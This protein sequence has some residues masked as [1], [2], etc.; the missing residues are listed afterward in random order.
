MDEKRFIELNNL[1]KSLKQSDADI[2]AKFDGEEISDEDYFFY[3]IQN[4][5]ISNTLNI[6]VN[7]LTGNIESV[8]VDNSCRI[9]L[10]VLTIFAMDDNGDISKTQK[11]IY[12]YIYSY[13]DLANF[14]LITTK[15]QFQEERFKSIKAVR[16]KCANYIKKHFGCEYED[17]VKPENGVDDPCFYLKKNLTDKIVFSKLI[18]KY[19][20]KDTRIGRL[21]EFFSIMAHPRYEM[22]PEVEKSAMQVHQSFVDDV[23]KLVTEFLTSKNLLPE[24]K[25]VNDFNAD[26]FYNPILANNVHN[27][28]E[29]ELAFNLTIDRICNRG[30]ECDWFN[31]FFLEK[32]KYLVLDMLTSFSLGYLEHVVTTF[33]PFIELFGVFH[34]VKSHDPT[35][36]EYLKRCYWITSRIQFNEHF[37]AYNIYASNKDYMEELQSLY[38]NYYSARYK[39]QT[40][41]KFYDKCLHNSLYF[42]DNSKKSFNK[43]V[44]ET[45]QDIA[46]DELQCKEF[47][48]LYKISKDM[49][50]ASG[51]SFNATPDLIAVTSHRAILTTLYVICHFLQTEINALKEQGADVDLS[52]VIETLKVHMQ[53]HA[54]AIGYFYQN[55][56]SEVG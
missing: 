6:L 25:D 53:F 30:G 7:Y 54:D 34:S 13:V 35:E 20:A 38:D 23:L 50:H 33:K 24:P 36:I 10:E 15:E 2:L 55:H 32:S 21:Y 42:L 31:L 41:K 11:R 46:T 52:A 49:A 44:R 5:I 47:I 14:K 48:I 45:F 43:F 18:D 37:K 51:Y 19:F 1:Y 29:I 9:I 39:V 40:F 3:G 56:D 28:R 22:N 8:G 26:F 17:I 12:R 4:D 16:N 27:I